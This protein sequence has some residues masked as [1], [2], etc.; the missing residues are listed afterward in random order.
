MSEQTNKSAKIEIV[1]EPLY[2]S[3]HVWL[4]VDGKIKIYCNPQKWYI[5]LEPDKE[6]AHISHKCEA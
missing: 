1:N 3:L 2:D 5:D 4:G 6:Q